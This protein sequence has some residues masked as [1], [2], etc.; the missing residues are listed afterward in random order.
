MRFPSIPLSMVGLL[1]LAGCDGALV[2]PR[3]DTVDVPLHAL[4]GESGSSAAMAR[5]SCAKRMG[6]MNNLHQMT[7]NPH[8]PQQLGLIVHGP[9]VDVDRGD[10]GRTAGTVAGFL[11]AEQDGEGCGELQVTFGDGSV[12]FISSSIDPTWDGES[13]VLILAGEAVFCPARDGPCDLAGFTGEVQLAPAEGQWVFQLSKEGSELFGPSEYRFAAPTYLVLPGQG[14]DERLTLSDGPTAL[15]MDEER[16]GSAGIRLTGLVG[17]AAVRG[18]ILSI[19][20]GASNTVAWAVLLGLLLREGDGYRWVLLTER[21][22]E[23]QA[24]ITPLVGSELLLRSGPTLEDGDTWV[25]GGVV[26]VRDQGDWIC[27]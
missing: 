26:Y 13:W 14:E 21:A 20:D 18:Q 2:A 7:L 6:A 16:I 15:W 17:T 10:D 19:A 23:R 9:S 27:L 12:R 1:A 11:L 25:L 8:R 4:L 22:G 5:T 24:P 3:T